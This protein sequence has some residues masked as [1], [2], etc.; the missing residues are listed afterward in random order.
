MLTYAGRI[1]RFGRELIGIRPGL[2]ET[3]LT[4]AWVPVEQP[5]R[6]GGG[7]R[8]PAA[9]SRCL[10]PRRRFEH[11]G[12]LQQLH[13]L[14]GAQFEAFGERLH[15]FPM[16]FNAVESRSGLI[17][18]GCSEHFG[19]SHDRI[20]GLEVEHSVELGSCCALFLERLQKWLQLLADKTTDSTGM[21][22][23]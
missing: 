13:G 3:R 17:A 2:R 19:Q 8:N 16:C 11:H 22:N 12:R 1:G 18:P 4:I 9:P 7:K 15:M 21:D 23:H 10:R 5:K 6:G 14:H 20:L